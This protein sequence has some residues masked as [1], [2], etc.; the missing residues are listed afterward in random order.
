MDVHALESVDLSCADDVIAALRRGAGANAAAACRSHSV[1]RISGPGRLIATGDLHDN[2]AHMA[3]LI[4]AAGLDVD[5]A[6]PRAA[7]AAHLTLHEIIHPDN[8]L[9]GMDFS[10]RAL[11]RAAALKAAFPEKVHMLLANHELAQIRGSGIVKDGVRVVEAFNA[12]VEHIFGDDAEAVTAAIDAFIASMPLALICDSARGRIL[13]SH[14]LPSPPM[15]KRFDATI[16]SR[17]ITEDDLRPLTGSAYMM[18]WGRGYDAELLEDLV[19]R[20][21]VTMFILGHEWVEAGIRFVPPC[22]VVLNSDHARG[23]YLP[24]DLDAP[25]TPAQAPR[26]A[27]PLRPAD[28]G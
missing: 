21:G 1:D 7:D 12:G 22:A 24:I 13:C 16:L 3:R 23:V 10:Y 17:P 25:P 4:E 5:P 9:G 2:P 20:W 6:G 19:E 11:V 14:S 28:A 26:L 15:M 27:V 18:V 8:L